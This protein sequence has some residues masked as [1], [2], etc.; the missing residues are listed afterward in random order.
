LHHGHDLQRVTPT[1]SFRVMNC[2]STQVDVAIAQNPAMQQPLESLAI[3]IISGLIV[4]LL[5]M[6]SVFPVF[7]NRHGSAG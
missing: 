1:Q 5:M 4:R 2:Q 6:T 7:G 3:A